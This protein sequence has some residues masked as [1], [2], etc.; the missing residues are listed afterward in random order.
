MIKHYSILFFLV[1]I[2]TI[3]AQTGCYNADFSTGKFDGWRASYGG[4]ENPNF[5]EGVNSAHHYITSVGILDSI[6]SSCGGELFMVPPGETY[7]A[8]LGNNAGGTEA[9]RLVYDVSTV[10]EDNN[11]FIYKYAV[12]LQDGGHDK[13]SQPNFSVRVLDGQGNEI[14]PFCGIYNVSSGEPNQNANTC[15]DIYWTQWNTVGINLSNY[16]GRS[17]SIEFTTRDCGFVKHFGYAYI[18]AKCSKLKVNVA[19]CEGGNNFTLNAPAGFVEY[20]WTYQG[21]VIGTPSQSIT[22]ALADYPPNAIFKCLLTSFN[23]GN[24]CESTIEAKLSNPTTI[25][26]DFSVSIPC[27]VD[28]TTFTPISFKDNTTIV[29]G[30]VDKWEWNFGDGKTSSLQNPN[31]MFENSGDYTVSLTAYSDGG[32]S[33]FISKPIHIENNPIS[34]P[35]IP[36]TQIMCHYPTPTLASLEK[37]G[38]DV[39]WYESLLSTTAID[40][41]TEIISNRDVYAAI[42]KDGCIGPMT[43]VSIT[44]NALGPP[45]G[46]SNQAFCLDETAPTIASLEIK[47]LSVTWYDA[48]DGGNLLSPNTILK[49]NVTYYSSDYDA[50]TGCSSS[51]WG[52]TVT[53][54]EG[55]AVIA[56]DFSQEFCL[57]DKVTIE[58][59]KYYKP[60]VRYYSSIN[61]IKQLP[62]TTPLENGTTYYAEIT[63]PVTKCKSSNRTAILVNKL[64]CDVDIYNLI[65][66]DSN[67]SNDHLK[68]EYIEYFPDNSIQVFNRFGQLVYKTSGYG[69]DQNYFFGFA[70]A[71]EIFMKNEKLP[72]GSYFYIL[73]Y[74]RKDLTNATRKGFL[75]IHNNE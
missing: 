58:N 50:A 20:K 59:L 52:I 51:R 72:T 61:D 31:H 40:Q 34:K 62:H 24:R 2:H 45:I 67:T 41:S 65:T 70:N 10:T 23:S 9:D 47:G 46:E 12:V 71:G 18:S 42:T 30:V 26:S 8:R 4:R 17:V 55:S 48:Q 33:S 39:N 68:I 73:D 21:Q 5:F 27:K 66:I 22:L 69:I 36:E 25:V 54:K 56:P 37:N 11:L 6:A 60:Y 75:Y 1:I 13:A 32:C 43:K 49:N 14:D 53:L 35:A 19:V 29:N 3:N 28:Y 74:K 16:I 57:K 38:I 44:L 15:G 7:A 63:D 64:P